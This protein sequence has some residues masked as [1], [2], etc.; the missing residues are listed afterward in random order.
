M[1]IRALVFKAENADSAVGVEL[2]LYGSADLEKLRQTSLPSAYLVRNEDLKAILKFKEHVVDRGVKHKAKG[3]SKLL[4]GYKQFPL[5]EGNFQS[6]RQLGRSVRTLLRNARKEQDQN[7]YFIGIASKVFDGI[8]EASQMGRNVS[9]SGVNVDAGGSKSI[10]ESPDVTSWMVQELYYRCQVP[11]DLE[12]RFIGNSPKAVLVRQQIVLAADSENEVLIIGDT[13]TGKE[14]VARA[15]HDFSSRKGKKFLAINCGGIP[16]TLVES[17]LFG[18][19]KGAFTGALNDKEGLW[20][21]AGEGT[22]F[23]DEIGDL[24]LESQAKILRTLEDRKIRP[25]GGKAAID[26]NARVIAATNRD[27]F[28]LV[29]KGEFRED[30]YYRLRSFPIR[31][32]ALRHHPEDIAVLADFMWKKITKENYKQLPRQIVDSLNSYSWPG[33]V[34]ELK[35]V[36]EN[37][38]LLFGAARLSLDH[39]KAVFYFE[40]QQILGQFAAT[41]P[42]PGTEKRSIEQAAAAL[43]QLKQSQEVVRSLEIQFERMHAQRETMPDAAFKFGLYELETLCRRPSLLGDTFPSV[44][45]LLE[46]LNRYYETFPSEAKEIKRG[47]S[48]LSKA[49][50]EVQAT[51]KRETKRIVESVLR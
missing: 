46:S 14:V 20:K 48:Q 2:P 33:N 35:K 37:L 9:D 17:E 12:Q 29:Q 16:S 49:F 30:L 22:L 8:W 43:H 24:H 45:D 50:K 47:E 41:K 34:R 10:D 21:T 3:L 6:A 38:H 18:Y 42:A 26:V 32:V 31:T 7:V 15:I 23:L 40:G 1:R 25:L 51:L 36:L 11:Q 5:I 28:A 27:L 44:W 39:L 19:V 4:L 13:G